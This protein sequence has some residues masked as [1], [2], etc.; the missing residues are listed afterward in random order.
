M[1]D[2]R[3][4]DVR[5]TVSGFAAGVPASPALG[6]QWIV[7]AE[8]GDK[9]PNA[10]VNSI[11]KYSNKGWQFINPFNINATTLEVINLTTNEILKFDYSDNQWKAVGSLGGL[12]YPFVVDRAYSKNPPANTASNIGEVYIVYDLDGDTNVYQITGVGEGGRKALGG[13]SLGQK[14]AVKYQGYVYRVASKT[15]KDADS[16]EDKI[17]N[18]FIHNGYVPN[19]S[20]IFAQRTQN[21]YL[22]G[23]STFKD[24]ISLTPQRNSAGENVGELTIVPHVFT[25]EEVA[26]KTIIFSDVIEEKNLNRVLCFYG[27]NVCVNGVDFNATPNTRAGYRLEIYGTDS[28]HSWYHNFPN[29]GETGIFMYF[30]K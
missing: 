4:L 14:V 16:G 11:A 24:L 3:F 6:D 22:S 7:S 9:Y 27:G 10:K 23:E 17:V 19:N 18:Y 15:V 21:V 30:K 5:I 20:L 28:H 12:I 29:A 8:W 26:A 13:L 25:A 1:I 2:R